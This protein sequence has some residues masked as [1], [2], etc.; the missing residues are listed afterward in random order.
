MPLVSSD[1][2]YLTA[3][4][5]FARDELTDKERNGALR[6]IAAYCGLRNAYLRMPFPAKERIVMDTSLSN[7]FKMC[8][9]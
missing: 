5:V 6:M 1:Y 4:G 9:G 8:C 2:L 3:S 7:C